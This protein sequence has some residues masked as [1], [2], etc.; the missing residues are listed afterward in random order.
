[1]RTFSPAMA[2]DEQPIPIWRLQSAFGGF[3]DQSE[4]KASSWA[5]TPFPFGPRNRGQSARDVCNPKV[6]I[7]TR[8][9][10]NILQ[11]IAFNVLSRIRLRALLRKS[12]GISSPRRFLINCLPLEETRTC[13]SRRRLR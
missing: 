5:M 3:D 7:D 11:F 6:T 10:E 13:V 4:L 12:S 9:R 1:M 2:K 8:L